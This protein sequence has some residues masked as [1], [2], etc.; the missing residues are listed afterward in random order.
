[1]GINVNIII[2]CSQLLYFGRVYPG[3][4]ITLF[5]SSLYTLTTVACHKTRV[6]RGP[7]LQVEP[8][9]S[10]TQSTPDGTSDS[11]LLSVKSR[12][13]E[14]TT[15]YIHSLSLSLSLSLSPPLLLFGTLSYHC[16]SSNIS[17]TLL[18]SMS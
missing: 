7:S 11:Y 9:T 6:C 15:M 16:W 1:M 4:Y 14:S 8:H 3:L 17:L 10:Y 18:T 12:R 13:K 2:L 5:Y